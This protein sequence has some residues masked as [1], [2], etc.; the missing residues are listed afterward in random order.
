MGKAMKDFQ[1]SQVSGVQSL[2]PEY[3]EAHKKDIIFF[4]KPETLKIYKLWR[5]GIYGGEQRKRAGATG[6]SAGI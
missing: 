1:N 5:M 6:L 4:S 2:T 3:P